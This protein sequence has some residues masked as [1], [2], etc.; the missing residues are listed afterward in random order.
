MRAI[1]VDD[2][3]IMLR[4]FMRNCANI[5]ELDVAAQFQSADEAISYAE[6]NTFELALLD[7]CLPHMN[8]IDL[9]VR[10][11]ELNPNLLIVFISAYDEYLSDFNKIGADFYILK[12]YKRVAI[13]MMVKRMLMLSE[14]I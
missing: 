4:S 7:V 9:A 14:Q 3:P 6:E 2:E 10:L 5:P 11:K 13:E 1:L 12:P 8:G